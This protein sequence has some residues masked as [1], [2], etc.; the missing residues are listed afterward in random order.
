MKSKRPKRGLPISADKVWSITEHLLE[1]TTRLFNL[2][3]NASR[4]TMNVD[5]IVQATNKAMYEVAG[6][7]STIEIRLSELEKVLTSIKKS[8]SDS[9]SD[10]DEDDKLDVQH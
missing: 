10:S 9:E 6:K 4:L 2:E 5:Q 3:H 8:E 7:I 1:H